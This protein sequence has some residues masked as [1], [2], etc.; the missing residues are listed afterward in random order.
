MYFMYRYQYLLNYYSLE[1][2]YFDV[3]IIGKKLS[4]V[5]SLQYTFNLY[6]YA[7]RPK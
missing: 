5:F 7:S 3:G 2:A 6:T 1:K 4:Y